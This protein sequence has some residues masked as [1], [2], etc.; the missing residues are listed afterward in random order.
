MLRPISRSRA[1]RC[2]TSSATG[3]RW[4]RSARAVRAA[5]HS[6]QRGDVRDPGHAGLRRR[7]GPHERSRGL[8]NRLA[9]SADFRIAGL[10]RRPE[11]ANDALLRGDVTMVLTMPHGFE[12]IDRPTSRGAVQLVVNA[13]KGSAAES[14]S[15]TR[16][17][18]SR[19]LRRARAESP[20]EAAPAASGSGAAA[21]YPAIDV[22]ARLV[23]P[24][25]RLQHYMV[26][27]IL[28]ALVTIIGTLLTAQNIAREKDSARSSSSTSRRSPRASSSPRSCCRSGCWHW[29][30]SRSAWWSDVSSSVCR[31]AGARCFCFSSA[32][33]YLVVALGIGLWIST[34]SRPSSRRC[35]SPSSC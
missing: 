32:G 12:A 26:P 22:R 17:R 18:S 5:A 16:R 29:S 33:V 4:R 25:A 2:C 9:A 27:G 1:P 30:I 6:V 11:L 19:L 10:A 21:A 31:C 14:C 34:L 13:E 3:R 35:S 7:P 23:Q 8:V 24:D 28:V 15:R 20:S